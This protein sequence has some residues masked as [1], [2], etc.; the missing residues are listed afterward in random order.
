[1]TKNSPQDFQLDDYKMAHVADNPAEQ[2]PT[3]HCYSFASE[4]DYRTYYDC[5]QAYAP[6]LTVKLF[7]M[8]SRSLE[9]DPG[10]RRVAHPADSYLSLLP[11]VLPPN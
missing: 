1:M 6:H 3:I 2:R 8:Y 11:V 4:A 10:V 9:E 7:Y 5:R